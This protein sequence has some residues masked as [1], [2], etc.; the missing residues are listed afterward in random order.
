VLVVAQVGFAL[1]VLFVAGLVVRTVKAIQHVPVG[2]TIGNILTSRVR[3]DPPTYQTDGARRRALESILDR[4]S[5][6]PGVT[7]AAVTYRLP[8][9]DGEASRRFTIIGR[10]PAAPADLPSAFEV[11]TLGDYPHALGV[12]LLE[13]RMWRVD[14]A[15]AAVA[16]VNR[17][18][19]RRYWPSQSPVGT[20]VA[21]VDANGQP[22]GDPIEIVGVVENVLS[23]AVTQPP[24]PRLYRPIAGRSLAS[25]VFIVRA[26]DDS[27]AIA[28][29]VREA[30]RSADR[31]LAV[32]EVLTFNSQIASV[33]RTYDLILA[34]FAGFAAIGLIVAVTG[35]YGVTAFSV[36]QR[37]HEIGVRM[38]LGA[39]AGDVV[40]LFV[41][42]S[43][44]LI[45]AGLA[46]GVAAG[47]AIGRAMGS[48]L[49]GTSASDPLTF[50]AVIGLLLVSG[51]V[52][53]L[54]PAWSAVSIDPIA[55][56]KRE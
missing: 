29:A 40:R 19:V 25:V 38:A 17:E 13:G 39:T 2:F 55:V 43:V 44:R 33:L 20:H 23:A 14:D 24:P 30:L 36:N 4:L 49:V 15:T 26:H 7:A 46:L 12:A 41:G 47:W 51:L 53:T 9:V 5:T 27:G 32:S 52:A 10:P 31:N 48:V 22:I 37:R 56:L 28:P 54:V 21:M 8:L 1:A 34:L 42:K 16:V 50:G 11:E 45:A 35:V 3:F 18:A 6:T